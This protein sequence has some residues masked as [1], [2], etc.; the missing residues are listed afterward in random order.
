[1]ST[2]NQRGD[3]GLDYRSAGVD[4]D[5]AERDKAGLKALLEATR[6]SNT[7]SAMGLFGGLYAV[8][9]GV[10][11]PVLVSSA[12]GVGTK[13][14]VAF[15]TG[16]HDT[17]GRDLV[18]HCVN[19]IL[20]QGAHPLFFLDYLATGRVREG[21]VQDIVRGVATAC[22]ENSCALLGG[23]TAQMPD[24]YGEG[25]YDLAGFIVGL[26]PRD[27]ILD[28][29]RVRDGDVLIGLPSSG[30]HTNGYTL[31]RR[32]LFD[33]AGLGVD[34]RVPGLGET[35]GEALLSVHRSYL[36]LLRDEL[37]AGRIRA[38]AHITGGGIP[39]NLPRSLPEGLGARVKRD[40][41]T[42]PPIF[43]ALQEL[44][45]VDD[46][47][48]LRVFNMGVGMILVVSPDEAPGMLDRLARSGEDAWI[49]GNVEAGTGVDFV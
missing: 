17:V 4:L 15:M 8:P 25:E 7:L 10:R 42:V 32:I 44:G 28:G 21:V 49:L 3:A 12:D 37:E 2:G 27:R 6:D 24:F 45:G 1:M 36:G 47:E 38:L 46:G 14:K 33:A 19:D 48:M 26:V 9:E 16:R 23:E 18:N 34:D 5:Q 11:D 20:V 40:S 31:A 13:L 29:S 22:A 30:L 41:W 43:A 39:G 35:A